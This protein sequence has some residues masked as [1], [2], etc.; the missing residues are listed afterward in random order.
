ML[1]EKIDS[2]AVQSFRYDANGNMTARPNGITQTYDVL[3]R[4]VS[5]KNGTKT[6]GYRYYADDMRKSKGG[7]THIWMNGEIVME[8]NGSSFID[9][10]HGEKLIKSSQ[11]GWYYYNSHGDVTSV[12][13]PNEKTI[14]YDY[15]PFGTQLNS[16]AATDTNPFRYNGEYYDYESGYIYLRTRY[17]D[18]ATGR[19][20]NED[21]TF[22]GDKWYAYCANDPVN[23]EDPSGMKLV[24]KGSKSKRNK[25]L[26]Q[27]EKLTNHKLKLKWSWFSYYVKIKSKAKANSKFRNG[28]KLLN[29]II[30][31]KK[32]CTIQISNRHFT[33]PINGRNAANL[34]GKAWPDIMKSDYDFFNK[35]GE[36]E[37]IKNVPMEE[38]ATVGLGWTRSYDITE[39]D[40]R[41]EHGLADR[42]KY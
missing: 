4:M 42:M 22:D 16:I 23:A 33:T 26:A 32:K 11:Y 41:E 21:P 15:N 10:V 5:Y 7:I 36:I 31:S 35:K 37:T 18:S 19:F 27:L 38:L 40:L 1:T 8:Y 12:I 13:D 20:V 3:N 39:N 9:Y 24:L 17:Y 28:N 25:I 14:S 6:T 34:K 2:Q 29:R 30:S